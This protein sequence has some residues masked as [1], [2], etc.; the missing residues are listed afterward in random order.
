[1]P[2]SEPNGNTGMKRKRTG[3]SDVSEVGP[4]QMTPGEFEM[5]RSYLILPSD[6]GDRYHS[7]D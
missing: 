2:I 4:Q 3:G 5:P 6:V 7:E 1:M